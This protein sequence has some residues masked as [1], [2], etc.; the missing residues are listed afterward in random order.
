MP[1]TWPGWNALYAAGRLGDDG[2]APAL[3]MYP[4]IHRELYT[5]DLKVVLDAYDPFETTR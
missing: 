5:D 2:L 3:G 1:F 4:Y